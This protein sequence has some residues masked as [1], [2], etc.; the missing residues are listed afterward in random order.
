MVYFFYLS[1]KTIMMESKVFKGQRDR[2]VI[3]VNDPIDV[4]YVHHQFPWLSYTEIR[5]V[6]KKYGPDRNA[7]QAVLERST[8]RTGDDES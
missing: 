7:V 8:H 3:D 6:I 5:D 4:E 2:R 1:R